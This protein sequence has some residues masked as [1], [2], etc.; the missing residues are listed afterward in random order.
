[1][2]LI[3]RL[4]PDKM[5]ASLVLDHAEDVGDRWGGPYGGPPDMGG[6]F[7]PHIF[8]VAGRYGVATRSYSKG[9]EAWIASRAD[10]E[11]MR[12]EPAI[13]ECLEAR[14]RSVSLLNWHIEPIDEELDDRT[15]T[16]LHGSRKRESG[17]NSEELAAK[18][19]L[20]L[21][22]T[23][24]ITKMFYSLMD[25]LWYGRYATYSTY[26]KT[27]ID[28][29]GWAT[30]IKKWE[31]RHGDKLVFRYND[32]TGQNDSDQVGIRVGPGYD[33]QSRYVDYAGNVRQQVEA[34]QYG[35][36]YWMTTNQRKHVAVHRHIIE[37]GDFDHPI[38][39]DSI[40][41][42][43]IRSRIY[44]TW[45][46]YS[47][48]FK[49]LMEYIERTAL[50]TEIW[51]YPAHNERAKEAT[52]EAAQRRGSPGRSI[53]MVP[54]P[55][56]EQ[57]DLY[58][59]DIVEPGLQ[60]ADVLQNVLHSFFGHK[61]KRYILG[62]T[63]SSEAESTGLGSGVANAHLATL[64]DIV[65][66]DARSLAE[67][68][69]TDILRPLQ[70]WN[71]PN[72]HGVYLKFK[73][74]TESPQAQ[75]KLEAYRAAWEMGTKIKSEDIYQI[76]GASRPSDGDDDVLDISGGQSMGDPMGGLPPAPDAEP[77]TAVSEFGQ[78]DTMQ[79][80][81]DSVA[82]TEKYGQ[83]DCD[84]NMKGPDGQSSCKLKR[85][86]T[87][88]FEAEDDECGA[89]GGP[90]NGRG[91]GGF[92]KDNT[93]ATG[94]GSQASSKKKSSGKEETSK[95]RT[96]LK[97][98]KMQK[99]I[100]G[101][102]LDL[103]DAIHE[104]LEDEGSDYTLEEVRDVAGELQAGNY[105]I[106]LESDLGRK[107]LV[108]AYEGS[109]Y[110]S[111]AEDNTA[112]SDFTG[113]LGEY[114]L[115]SGQ[116]LR[117]IRQAYD[118]LGE[119]LTEFLGPEND[120]DPNDLLEDDT[121]T[122]AAES[123][124]EVKS[125]S[126]K[127]EAFREFFSDTK[128]VDENGEPLVVHH[129]TKAK[130]GGSFEFDLDRLGESTS[131]WS[132][133]PGFYFTESKSIADGYSGKDGTR[134][135][136][137]LNIKKPMKYSEPSFGEDVLRDIVVRSAEIE[138]EKEGI[139]IEDTWLANYGG[140]EGAVSLILPDERALDQMGGII[141]SGLSARHLLQAVTEVTGFDGI[142]S[143]GFSDEGKTD[144]IW[145]AFSPNQIKHIDNKNPSDS[146]DIYD[147][148]VKQAGMFGEDFEPGKF[149]DSELENLTGESK[150]PVKVKE[151]QAKMFD[152]MDDDPDQGLM[153]QDED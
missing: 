10:C 11:I 90:G 111:S 25:A 79:M 122:E 88:R 38:K 55:E 13:M 50:G 34:T 58:N 21:K 3:P 119:K 63:L 57:A 92:K 145:V 68:I 2:Q 75:Q 93:C 67:T 136:V 29:M 126:P 65:T 46:A 42:I 9:D 32:N 85:H 77:M 112:P 101:D 84:P 134:L 149:T 143:R 15:K 142:F 144:N 132:E 86:D 45:K 105:D 104:A 4:E 69:T 99:E 117:S 66:W 73:F 103:D 150:K 74:D 125:S 81:A 56:G 110:V 78:P 64:A 1:M 120:S 123:D 97:L 91:D 141:N 8:T 96:T 7:L 41:G 51:R 28:G 82:E 48:C 19:S 147:S 102:R 115:I 22:Y 89:G 148:E 53:L 5:P 108:D 94:D 70:L 43:G 12:N 76:I 129:G 71:F 87:E 118:K 137:Y 6:D 133:G 20:I 18:M 98:T 54:V 14:M 113:D 35:L 62:Q 128:V 31:P 152:A 80:S 59:V 130:V 39:A 60:G 72:S 26:A 107:V 146:D 52:E 36:A 24:N 40:H 124:S 135:D 151:K 27:P 23:P 30:T 44:W 49:L 127:T 116:K 83:G 17:I 95:P 100:L 109:T 138:S 16:I 139:D 33:T 47:E 114:D 131:A 153:F 37:D 140:V 61:M 121:P 106:A